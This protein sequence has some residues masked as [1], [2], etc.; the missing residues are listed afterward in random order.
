MGPIGYIAGLVPVC[1]SVGLISS[2]IDTALLQMQTERWN[3]V[4]KILLHCPGI[5]RMF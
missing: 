1:V 2:W 4:D 5:D 3:C